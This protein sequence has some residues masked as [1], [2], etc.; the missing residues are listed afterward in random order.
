MKNRAATKLRKSVID[1]LGQRRGPGIT[2]HSLAWHCK[3]RELPSRGTLFDLCHRLP[4][5]PEAG[6]A[7]TNTFCNH[8]LWISDYAAAW[9][10]RWHK[11]SPQCCHI[12][13]LYHAKSTTDRRVLTQEEDDS[14]RT[15]SPQFSTARAVGSLRAAALLI[16]AFRD[17]F[18]VAIGSMAAAEIRLC[19]SFRSVLG[20]LFDRT[21]IM[22]HQ[23][24]RPTRNL[25]PPARRR[26]QTGPPG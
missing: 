13:P 15:A 10:S 5:V 18:R 8:R 20:S 25:V 23:S 4:G 9:H 24:L 3:I 14:R 21:Q 1:L 6:L 19:K 2:P 11:R 12:V 17:R 22:N 7:I 26:F 16:M